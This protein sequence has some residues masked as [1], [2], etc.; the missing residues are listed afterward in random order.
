MLDRPEGRDRYAMCGTAEPGAAD[1]ARVICSERHSWRAI[2][3][4]PFRAGAYPG[5]EKVRAAGEAPCQDAASAVADDS[6]SFQ[7]GYEWP[8]AEQWEAGQTYGLCWAPD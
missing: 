3:T 8:T 4:V 6:L 7:W 5:L 2:T 1:F